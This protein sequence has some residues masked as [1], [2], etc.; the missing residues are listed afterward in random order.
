MIEGRIIKALSGF[1]YVKATNHILYQCRARGLFK[2]KG[3]SP[4]VGDWV[5]IEEIENEGHIT[6]E[7]YI[8]QIHSRYSELIRPPIANIDLAVVVFSLADPKPSLTLLD[9]FLAHIE[10]A[11][12]N[13]MIVL[14]KLDLVEMDRTITDPFKS[15]QKMGYP[16]VYTSV[17]S[18]EGLS[19]LSDY[20]TGHI[21]VL[22]GQSGVGKSS[23]LNAL[24]PDLNLDTSSV[25]MKLGRGK[26]T[27]R[28]VEL[29][30]LPQDGFVADAPGFSQLEFADMEIEDLSLCF[31]E[32][33]TYVPQCKFRGCL[34]RKEPNCA[35]KRAVEKGDILESRYENYLQF[36]EEIKEKRRRY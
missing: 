34:H 20:L 11:H 18:G 15:Y 26:H 13:A 22:C 31:R 33:K 19:V 24:I 6:N 8:T 4:L 32:I 1:Y 2:K 35:V 25:S 17:K 21:S 27:T 7:G 5:T 29:I 28:H 9:K 36:I 23:I 3:I 12:V 10:Y 16:V 30:P 14:T